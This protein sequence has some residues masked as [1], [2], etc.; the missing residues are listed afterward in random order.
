MTALQA[1]LLKFQLALTQF[2]QN[3]LPEYAE[4]AMDVLRGVVLNTPV[5]T[6]RARGNWQVTT[7]TPATGQT[8]VKTK[9]G[10]RAI[11]DGTSKINSANVAD[12]TTIW[13]T[14]NVPY[15]ERLEDGWSAQKPDGILL[16]TLNSIRTGT[17]G[18]DGGSL[19][20]QA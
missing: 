13:I 10:A 16:P 6:G 17:F 5:D 9:N 19:E 7:N 18:G 15:I 11:Q 12:G 2:S 14:N 20:T 8:Q 4:V 3:M 1:E